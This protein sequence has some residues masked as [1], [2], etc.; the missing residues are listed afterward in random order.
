MDLD[1][2]AFPLRKLDH[3]LAH[4]DAM[5]SLAER[6]PQNESATRDW[7]NRLAGFLRPFANRASLLVWP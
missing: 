6:D 7:H 5:A 2:R 3:P 1:M 4:T